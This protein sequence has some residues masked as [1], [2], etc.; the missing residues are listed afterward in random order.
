MVPQSQQTAGS[1]FAYRSDP[2]PAPP[3]SSPQREPREPMKTDEAARYLGMSESW[4]RQ[5]R[6]A[7]RMSQPP[8]YHVIGGR[9]VRYFRHEIESWLAHRAPYGDQCKLP[10]EIETAGRSRTRAG[11]Y[12]SAGRRVQRRGEIAPPR[13]SSGGRCRAS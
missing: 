13:R 5:S 1:T 11:Q 7:G 9:A 4:L 6:M 3:V 12:E 10:P 2:A 8:P